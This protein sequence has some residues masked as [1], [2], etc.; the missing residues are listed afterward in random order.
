MAW[1]SIIV[2]AGPAGLTAALYLA[3]YRRRTL[4]LHDGT[5]RAMRIP[6]TMNVPGFPG[7]VA[8]PDLVRQML[9]HAEEFGARIAGAHVAKVEREKGHFTVHADDGRSWQARSLLLATGSQW[10]EAPLPRGTHEAAMAAG[11]LRYCPICDGYEH[12]SARIGVIGCDSSGVA[13]AMFLKT[14]SNDITLIPLSFTELTAPEQARLSGAG[15]DVETAP[16][17]RLEP[18]DGAMRVH[19]EGAPPREFDVVYPALGSRPRARLALSLGLVADATGTLAPSAPFGTAVPGLYAA[20]DVVQGLD[21]I[22]VAMGHGAIA[23]TRAH[24]YLR[25]LDEVGAG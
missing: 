7:G 2:G 8:G 25:E 1:D 9:G 13:E 23:A 11:I 24:N 14:Y 18:L 10:I 16:L 21:Q 15:I 3:R 20:G 22:S 6:R 19:L 5:A 17:D 12:R 4:V